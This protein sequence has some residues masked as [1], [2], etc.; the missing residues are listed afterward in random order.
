M[1][2]IPLGYFTP[3]KAGISLE[4]AAALEPAHCLLPLFSASIAAGFPSPAA[5]H[6]DKSIDLNELLVKDPAA[7]FFLRVQGD[8]MKLAGI[9]DGSMVVVDA[10]KVAQPGA[11]VVA[12]VDGQFTLKRLR[13]VN[14]L[15]ELHPE[16]PEFPVIRLSQG[17]NLQIF[18]VVV[19][20]VTQF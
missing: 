18:G 4:A 16:N 11:I 7:T 9:L 15:Y 2:S 10:G 19:A 20:C 13:R 14:G 3:L 12:Q 17:G 6:I 1:N 5:D 8:S